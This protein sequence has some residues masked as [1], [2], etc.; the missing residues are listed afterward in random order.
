MNSDDLF[1]EE[2]IE[3]DEVYLDLCIT[4]IIVDQLS[5]ED[6]DLGYK[7]KMVIDD[8][9]LGLVDMKSNFSIRDV[10]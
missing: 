8:V 1:C 7:K 2:E 9:G 5:L 6:S 4:I 3:S 10:V